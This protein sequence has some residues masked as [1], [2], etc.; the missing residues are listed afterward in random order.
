MVTHNRYFILWC[1]MEWAAKYPIL[2]PGVTCINQLSQPRRVSHPTCSIQRQTPWH[3][4]K[5]T[6]S[7]LT[8]TMAYKTRITLSGG[9]RWYT[10]ETLSCTCNLLITSRCNSDWTASSSIGAKWIGTHSTKN[11]LNSLLMLFR[12]LT[13]NLLKVLVTGSGQ[14]VQSLDSMVHREQTR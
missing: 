14:T 10:V 8:P 12:L 4:N 1:Q 11:R 5:L 2:E 7:G 9:I 13:A 3:Q 6:L